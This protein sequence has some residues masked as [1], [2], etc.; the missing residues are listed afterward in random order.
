MQKKCR[1]W[2]KTMIFL[3][4][5]LVFA[6]ASIALFAHSMECFDTDCAV[7]IAI[8][9][10]RKILL[11]LVLV[12]VGV[13]AVNFKWIIFIVRSRPFSYRDITP[14]GLKVKLSN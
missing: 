2:K 13:F 5:L 14:V 7:C 10:S 6:Y 3:C 9:A 4:V 8:E 1:S 12:A 11:A